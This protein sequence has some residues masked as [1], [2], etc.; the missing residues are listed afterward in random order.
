MSYRRRYRRRRRGRFSTPYKRAVFGL[1]APFKVARKALGE[2]RKLKQF[3]NTEVK[4]FDT[5]ISNTPSTS[6]TV[7]CLNLIG[8]GD[9]SVTRDGDSIKAIKV[10][11]NF[12]CDI[13][14]SATL[15]LLR[16]IVIQDLQCRGSNPTVSDYLLNTNVNSFRN[17]VNGK[18]FRTLYDRKLRLDSDGKDSYMLSFNRKL[19]MHMRYASASTAPE[20][21][22]IYLITLSG[23]ATN[24][25]TVA[26]YT[27]I[28][29][30][31]N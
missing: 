14:A 2:V 3:I 23:E 18:R 13:H 9:T 31:D 10:Q 15:T 4:Y 25:P 6:G 1:T 27:R 11:F 24:V 29:F 20:T 7:T 26:G 21:N 5:T 30:V 16:V 17:L 22:G 8:Q 19:N 28:R 12:Y